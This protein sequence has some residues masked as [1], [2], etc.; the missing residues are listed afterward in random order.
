MAMLGRIIERARAT[1]KALLELRLAIVVEASPRHWDI[2]TLC[3]L[4]YTV[5]AG[6]HSLLKCRTRYVHMIGKR[7]AT[8]AT[9]ATTTSTTIRNKKEEASGKAKGYEKEKKKYESEMLSRQD[10]LEFQRRS[11]APDGRRLLDCWIEDLKIR[12]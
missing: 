3:Q 11:S 10:E 2:Y 1:R 7:N 6:Y 4:T 9:K 12:L 5:T 8:T